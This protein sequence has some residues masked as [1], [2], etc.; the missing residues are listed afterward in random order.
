VDRDSG[1]KSGPF[2]SIA[3]GAPAVKVQIYSM[4]SVADALATVA[5]G[6]DLVGVLVDA[7][8]AVPEAVDER[9]A[10]G[11]VRAAAGRALAVALSMSTDPDEIC[12]MAD[13]VRPDIVQAG[14]TMLA[15]DECYEV[16]ERIAPIKLMRTLSFA[17][18]EA[19]RIAALYELASDYLVLAPR[20]APSASASAANYA[21]TWEVCRRVV[22]H[23]RIPVLLGGALTEENVAAAIRAVHPWGVESFTTTDL[24]G[25]RGRKDPAR[26]RAFI[27]AARAASAS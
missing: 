12:A 15:A 21:K 16:R 20:A 4:T 27:A 13:A 25:Q 18:P 7:A 10:R 23:A 8:R 14:A 24:A 26:V 3:A 5:A 2:A 17:G 11:I 19:I 1:G 6:A 22:D 9:A